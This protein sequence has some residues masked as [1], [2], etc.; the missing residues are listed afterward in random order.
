MIGKA[1][2][3]IVVTLPN[4]ITL[5]RLALVPLTLYLILEGHTLAAFWLFLLAGVSDAVDGIIARL[6]QV[7]SDLGA[8]L[9]P[10]ADKALL[11]GVYIVMALVGILPDWLVWL[12]VGRDALILAGFGAAW[13]WRARMAVKPSLASKVNTAVQIALAAAALA[14]TGFELP[15]E[16][17]I[18]GLVAM[19]A[20]T[21]LVSLAG[22]AAR[23]VRHLSAHRV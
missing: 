14:I 19:V 23:W 2:G 7:Q 1:K 12:V 9:D 16:G 17:V 15:L 6:W 4:L 10:L 8:M 11:V 13:L 21:T 3:R 20:A 22:Y 5:V 18:E